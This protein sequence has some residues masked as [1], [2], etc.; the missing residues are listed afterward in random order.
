MAQGHQK[1]PR[2]AWLYIGLLILAVMV[3]WSYFWPKEFKLSPLQ[4]EKESLSD[5]IKK[6]TDS[7]NQGGELVNQFKGQIGGKIPPELVNQLSIKVQAELFQE[8]TASWQEWA[9]E[10]I[11]FKLPPGWFIREGDGQFII[12][13]YDETLSIKPISR[14][15]VEISIK[16]GKT[17]EEA[18]SIT[19]N[20]AG[21]PEQ[22]QQIIEDF[23]KTIKISL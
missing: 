16:E 23:H 21:E 5:I 20:I 10:K 15:Q 2:S 14:A 9:N 1:I 3:F 12:S 8:R 4:G 19:Q 13:S 6:F 17:P 11:S 18:L 7:V 22:F